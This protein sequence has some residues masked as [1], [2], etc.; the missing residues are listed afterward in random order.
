MRGGINLI[1]AAGVIHLIQTVLLIKETI[2]G[3]ESVIPLDCRHVVQFIVGCDMLK[4]AALDIERQKGIYSSLF[5]LEEAAVFLR[6]YAEAGEGND[7]LAGRF[8]GH[9]AAR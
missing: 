7:Y 8:A 6:V 3:N 2:I 4:A 9:A 5:V 1:A